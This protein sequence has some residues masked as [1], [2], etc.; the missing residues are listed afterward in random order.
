MTKTVRDNDSIRMS[1]KQ[2]YSLCRFHF[3]LGRNK[4]HSRADFIGIIREPN[5]TA[6]DV[7]TRMLQTEKNCEFDKVTPAELVLSKVL[8]LIGRSTRNNELEKKIRTSYRT[9]ELITDITQSI[10]SNNSNDGRNIK[11]VG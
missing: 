8:S 5:E 7:W 3:I 11:H 6:A 2:L 4:F 9:I 1:I 10:D